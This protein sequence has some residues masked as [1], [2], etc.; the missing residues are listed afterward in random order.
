MTGSREW[1]DYRASAAIASD[2]A[3]DFGLAVRVQGLQRFYSLVVTSGGTAEL[4]KT[5]RGTRILGSAD[6]HR[7]EG[8][9]CFFSVEAAGNRIRAG[10]DGKTLFDVIDQK[11][12]LGGGGIALVC[13][14]GCISANEV[15]VEPV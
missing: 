2:M 6:F 4:R 12:P 3:A 7:R 13:K 9:A 5:L 14:E 10:I 11:E 15:N 1:T 8:A